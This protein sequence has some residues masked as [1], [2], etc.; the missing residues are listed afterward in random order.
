MKKFT[1]KEFLSYSCPCFGCGDAV[2]VLIGESYHDKD[3]LNHALLNGSIDTEVSQQYLRVDLKISYKDALSLTIDH[4][5]NRFATNN[6]NLLEKYLE[7]HTIYLISSCGKCYTTFESDDLRFNM[8]MEYIYAVEMRSEILAIK[9]DKQ[10][11]HLYSSYKKNETLVDVGKID[12]SNQSK[13][14]VIMGTDILTL[15]LLPAYKMKTKE[16][17]IKKL[18]TY[19]LFS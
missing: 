3:K 17:L 9:K 5:T 6:K 12:G 14:P 18:K 13:S 7:E 10:M 11:F 15:P 1:V 8:T 19:L 2:S 16:A 4:K